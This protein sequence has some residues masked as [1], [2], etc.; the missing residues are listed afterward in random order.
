MTSLFVSYA[1]IYNHY[2][3]LNGILSES[4][5][6]KDESIGQICVSL[7]TRNEYPSTARSKT[8]AARLECIPA[9]LGA[10]TPVP[11]ESEIPRMERGGRQMAF[12]TFWRCLRETPEATAI[13]TKFPSMASLIE[14]QRSP[15]MALKSSMT[16]LPRRSSF[17]FSTTAGQSFG[18]RSEGCPR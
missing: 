6:L 5:H 4:A 15:L 8:P 13:Q 12:E 11:R 14:F 3:Y 2:K 17:T 18:K 16:E 10:H 1:E 7:E 9:M